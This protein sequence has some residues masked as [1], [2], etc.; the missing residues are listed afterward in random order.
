M[1][2]ILY[3]F[4]DSQSLEAVLNLELDSLLSK[5]YGSVRTKKFMNGVYKT[6]FD[7]SLFRERTMANSR[8]RLNFTSGTIIFYHS[9]HEQSIFVYYRAL[10]ILKV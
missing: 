6:N 2:V 7:C 4:P 10:D 3:F 5:F 8:P 1:C 9:P